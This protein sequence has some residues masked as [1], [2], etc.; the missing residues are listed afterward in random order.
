MAKKENYNDLA[1]SGTNGYSSDRLEPSFRL[2]MEV[3][4]VMSE[5]V[6]TIFPDETASTAARMMAENKISCMVVVD[7]GT[8]SGI[9]TEGNF[10]RREAEIKR[11][12]DEITVAEVMT[13][14]VETVPPDYSIL[15]ASKMVAE[16][17]IKRLPVIEDGRLIGIITQ[18][19]LIRAL[20]PYGMQWEIANI[21]NRDVTGIQS[22]TS[23][24]EVAEIMASHNI[25]CIVVFESKK[26]AGVFTE[27]DLVKKVIAQRRDP[28]C[29]A[30]GQVM[31]GPP[32]TVSPDC[33]VFN[34][35]RMMEKMKI[36]RLVVMED[37]RLCGI[38]TQ[39]DILMAVR[40]RLQTGDEKSV[41]VLII[42]DDKEDA[43]ILRS[44]LG[45]CR[46]YTIKSE[47]AGGMDNALKK[48]SSG[49]FDLIFL[50]N[51]LGG[52]ATADK[53]LKRFNERN[54]DVPVIIV[55]SQ[56]DQQTAI[57]LMKM[58]AYDHIIRDNLKPELI[59]RTIRTIFE[60]HTLKVM[61]KQ[62][63]EALQQSEE[64]YRRITN[65]ITDYIYTVRLENEQV[66][67]TVH[68]EACIAVTG[69]S[70]EEFASDPYL[71]I[72]MVHP[73]DRQEVCKQASQCIS[74][75]EIEPL[76]HRIVHKDGSVRWLKSTL[77][78]C[79]DVQDNLVSYDGLLQD[80]TE[81]KEAEEKMRRARDDAEKAQQELESV[82]HQ[83]AASVERANLMTQQAIAADLAK[84]QFLA[85]MSH[86][87][88]TPMNAIIG[89]SEV[90]AEEQLS[91][92]QGHYVDIIHQSAES[93]LQLINDILDFSKIEAGKLN[94]EIIDC[95]L[96]H[97]FTAV[98]LLIRPEARKKGLEFEII[99]NSQLPAKIRTDPVRLRQCL[100]NLTNNAVKFTEKGHVYVYVSLDQSDSEPYIRFDV[101]DTGIGI[102]ADKQE[103][104]FEIFT[105]TDS[106][107]ARKYGG[108]GLGLAIT[109]QLARLLSGE[110]SLKSELGKGSV[111]SL[112][113]PAGIDVASEP[114]FG[115]NSRKE[116]S[117]IEKGSSEQEKFFGQVLV[118]EDSKTNQV[119]IRIL[120]ERLGLEVT[121]VEDGDDAVDKALS[122]KYDLIF[123]DIQM[124]NMSGYE[125]TKVLR[126]NKIRTP[127]VALTAHAMRGDKQKCLSAGCDGYLPKPIS[128]KELVEVLRRYLSSGDDICGEEIDAPRFQPAES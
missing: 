12:F 49:Y 111:F 66:G 96:E 46:K 103:L 112:V 95:S 61:Q 13:C 76:E 106:G 29:I 84:S 100:L 101:E 32:V 7:E 124:P 107:I 33:S 72:N 79:Y 97:L 116:D 52:G 45:R 42:D 16:K 23:V 63:E 68:N 90:L 43:K 99:Q 121:L 37:E 51:R 60:R 11:D 17:C 102:A 64:R 6:V 10:L 125:A 62:S 113:V 48:L 74:G 122:G 1:T 31:S 71:W 25:S 20:T 94:I 69:Y 83:L 53:M 5:R 47:Y 114:V 91:K 18:T 86:E 14:P 128:R 58:G 59:E 21:M 110:L 109:K 77:V 3:R 2:W 19:D 24:A 98:E 39:T 56:S 44:H 89:F 73:D 55:T 115:R 85:N 80:I 36:R 15:K 30:V 118:A 92:D 123:M 120:L 54:I 126:R 57:D 105:Q 4:D 40:K 117:A 26:V 50:A 38:V 87:I 82:N 41:H 67:E 70:S 22:E 127:I 78:R 35:S 8:V 119:L 88:R 93:L 81:R 65:A 9:L 28:A 27:R 34:A 108:T 75:E 104:I